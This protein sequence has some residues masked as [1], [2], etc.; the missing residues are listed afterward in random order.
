MFINAGSTASRLIDVRRF[1]PIS[2]YQICTWSIS[3]WCRPLPNEGKAQTFQ[4]RDTIS[5]P[6]H[7]L[8]TRGMIIPILQQHW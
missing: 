1:F 8:F 7:I 5:V 4:N 2:F 6:L 3:G